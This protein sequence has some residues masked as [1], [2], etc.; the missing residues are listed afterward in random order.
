MMLNTESLSPGE[1]P[2]ANERCALPY[3]SLAVCCACTCALHA[4][5]PLHDLDACA[6]ARVCVC[7]VHALCPVSACSCAV[8]FCFKALAD[9]MGEPAAEPDNEVVE[10]FRELLGTWNHAYA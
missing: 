1:P 4:A 8:A 3:A 6:C 7:V 5:A 9:D 2:W 10:D